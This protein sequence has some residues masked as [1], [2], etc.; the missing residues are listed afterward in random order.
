M[1]AA[2]VREVCAQALAQDLEPRRW[3]HIPVGTNIGGVGYAFTAGDL[4]FDPVLE[5]PCDLSPYPVCDGDC[6]DGTGCQEVGGGVQLCMPL[7]GTCP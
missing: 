5:I 6:P 1:P 2:V 3:A 7:S 4:E